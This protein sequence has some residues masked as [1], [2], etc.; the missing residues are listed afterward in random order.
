MLYLERAETWVA[1]GAGR[2]Q[3]FIGLLDAFVGGL[4]V[5]PAAHRAGIGRALV[6]H[7][8]GRKGELSVDVY[9][10]NAAALAFYARLGFVPVGHRDVDDEGRPLPLVQ[11][12]RPAG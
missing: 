4:F 9:A 2:I 8:A 6:E 10:A 3:G 1:L 5:D 12:H 7:A 11:L